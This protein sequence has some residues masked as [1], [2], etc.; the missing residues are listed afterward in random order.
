MKPVCLV[1]GAGAGIGGTVAKKF[2]TRGLSF[3]FMPTI[4]SRR[5]GQIGIK[6]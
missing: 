4:R 1:L 6:Y 2:A 3:L 5:L